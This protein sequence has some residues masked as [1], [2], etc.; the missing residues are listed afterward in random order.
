MSILT[1][2]SRAGPCNRQDPRSVRIATLK[3]D[4]AGIGLWTTTSASIHSPD[5]KGR[6][7]DGVPETDLDRGSIS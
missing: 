4:L 6:D 1:L 3:N 5:R 7:P 2:K